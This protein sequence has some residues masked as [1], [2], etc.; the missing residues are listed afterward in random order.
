MND[1]P[2]DFVFDARIA[3]SMGGEQL[4]TS[5]KKMEMKFEF[6]LFN[7][8]FAKTVTVKAGSFDAVTHERFLMMSAIHGGVKGAP[9]LDLGES[10]EFPPLKIITSKNVGTY[11]A[12]NKNITVEEVVDEPVVKKAAPKRRPAPAVGELV[13]K[14]KRTTLGR[15]TPAEKD[16]AMTTETA[17]VET[18]SRID[19]STISNYDE[20]EPLVETEKEA[21]KEKDIEPVAAEG[22]SLE[23][24]TDSEYTEPLSKVLAHT[25]KY[26]PDEESMSIDVAICDCC[27]ANKNQI[28]NCL[29]RLAVLGSVSDIVAKEELILVWAETDSL[30]TA[31]QR[32]FYITSMPTAIFSSNDYAGAF[33]Q[34]K[35]SVDQIS[36]EQVQTRFHMENIKAALF[37]KIS[38][39][40]TAFLTRYDNQEMAVFV[41]TDVLRKEMQAQ[42]AAMSQGLD[43]IR[44]EV[45]D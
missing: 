15:V 43:V 4:K 45:Q 6:R 40:E 42:K 5:C 1:V 22:M 27:R 36:L 14:N 10:K 37:T 21:E 12:K 28:R 11:V 33:A 19:V 24:I 30:H 38:S 18:E 35:A 25:E 13:A 31:V 39:L 44:R 26:M 32:R 9:D 29:R 34:L 7:E 17:A 8:I 2:K 41:Q 16:L 3:F 23:K 20:E